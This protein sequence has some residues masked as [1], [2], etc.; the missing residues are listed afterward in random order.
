MTGTW[1]ITRKKNGGLPGEVGQALGRFGDCCVAG[2]WGQPGSGRGT[3]QTSPP[4]WDAQPII[5]LELGS[6]KATRGRMEQKSLYSHCLVM[7]WGATDPL[8]L[9]GNSIPDAPCMVYLPISWGGLRG[10]CKHIW[11]S[12]GVSSVWELS[13]Y[14]SAHPFFTWRQH[15]QVHVSNPIRG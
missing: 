5:A 6:N 4:G 12:H 3:K 8:H 10:Q 15:C 14:C 9:Q 1:H 7:A 2:L 11:Q 13:F